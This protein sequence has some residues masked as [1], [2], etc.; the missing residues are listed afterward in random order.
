DSSLLARMMV[1]QLDPGA[2]A[3]GPARVHPLE[4]LGPILAFGAAGAGVDLDISVVGVRLAREQRG[5]LVALG[6]LGKL[7]EAADGVVDQRSIAFAFGELDQFY[8]VGEFAL[9]RSGR[10]DRL[11]QALAL[12]HQVLS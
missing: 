6:A 4:H 9:N 8:G 11:L 12:A 3:L 1:D 7:V 10:S 5:D 2:V